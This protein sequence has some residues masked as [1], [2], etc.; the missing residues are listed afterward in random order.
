MN[1]QKHL[2]TVIDCPNSLTCI[3]QGFDKLF[4]NSIKKELGES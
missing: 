2:K 4:Q 3:R 1:T